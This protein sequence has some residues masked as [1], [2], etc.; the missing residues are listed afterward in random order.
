M[1]MAIETEQWEAFGRQVPT[2]TRCA[3]MGLV[4]Q[5]IQV[6]SRP[7]HFHLATPRIAADQGEAP[8]AAGPDHGGSHVEGGPTQLWGPE[9]CTKLLGH[10][11]KV[12]E[13]CVKG[14][15]AQ[16]WC[17]EVCAEPLDQA[18][19]V[20]EPW[21]LVG[22]E[23]TLEQI[24]RQQSGAGVIQA[25]QHK[26]GAHCQTTASE[27]GQT[28]EWATADEGEAESPAGAGE[29]GP[30]ARPRA[31]AARS[32]GELQSKARRREAQRTQRVRAPEEPC[33]R[34]AASP[35]GEAQ[36]GRPPEEPSPRGGASPRGGEGGGG[37]QTSPDCSEPLSKVDSLL[38]SLLQEASPSGAPIPRG[39]ELQA[40]PRGEP[41]P[42]GVASP[43]AGEGERRQT[44]DEARPSAE[45]G[46][47]QG[48]KPF[49]DDKVIAAVRFLTDDKVVQCT[50]D[51]KRAFLTRKGLTEA[52][53]AEALE[54]AGPSG[55]AS[56]RGGDPQRLRVWGGR[57][58]EGARSRS[59][60]SSSASSSDV[61]PV[62]PCAGERQASPARASGAPEETTGPM[63]ERQASPVGASSD[64]PLQGASVEVVGLVR[65][66][67]LNGRKGTV[68]SGEDAGGRMA[69][70]LD[71]I[72]GQIFPDVVLQGPV[73][74][75]VKA[76]N[77]SVV[78][79]S[80]L[81]LL[82]RNRDLLWQASAVWEGLVRTL[83]ERH[84]EVVR[85]GAERRRLRVLS[86]QVSEGVRAARPPPPL[87]LQ[88]A[89]AVC[90]GQEAFVEEASGLARSKDMLE[91]LVANTRA[92]IRH[93]YPAGK[94]PSYTL[95]S[96]KRLLGG[97][98][99]TWVG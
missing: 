70:R 5:I 91:E 14:G 98:A 30:T 48:V 9:A 55:A 29:A 68:L 2:C 46:T 61:T 11:T 97:A 51:K 56:P 33:P 66:A 47:L 63:G 92:D 88:M 75:R 10:A 77:L 85:L 20:A 24:Q 93:S 34:G 87:L 12:A 36:R 8:L 82:E 89:D 1:A 31:A 54:R 52:E 69:V 22:R 78:G 17:P 49:R 76:G 59:S 15:P 67:D 58:S 13:H 73:E 86:N 27:S 42:R 45:D 16:L 37:F 26:D 6:I 35:R 18:R 28:K 3:G 53:V 95:D 44:P 4:P 81:E 74:V 40:R 84:P 39:G 83:G 38:L 96:V 21:T 72:K 23:L 60:S 99:G 62:W 50:T 79:L 71:A 64:P 80:G 19:G 7:I 57:S 41:S 32:D 65:R 94:A 43:S 90:R 25:R